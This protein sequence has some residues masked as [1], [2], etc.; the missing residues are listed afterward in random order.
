M[1]A[2]VVQR[3]R[4]SR[5]LKKRPVRFG[6]PHHSHAVLEENGRFVVRGLVLDPEKGKAFL[7]EHG[8]FM[9]ENA[10]DLSEPTGPVVLEAGSVEELIS[11]LPSKF[12]ALK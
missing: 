1:L 10:E 3:I 11:L 9:P 8:H 7:R 2:H 5:D 6:A 12:P 4:G